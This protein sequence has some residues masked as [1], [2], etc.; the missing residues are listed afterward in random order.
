MPPVVAQTRLHLFDRDRVAYVVAA[1]A[2]D[3]L[4]EL[5]AHQAVLHQLLNGLFR[6]A[7]LLVD[8]CCKRLYFVERELTAHFLEQCF[9][10]CK[11]KI[12][13]IYLPKKILGCTEKHSAGCPSAPSAAQLPTPYFGACLLLLYC[14][15]GICQGFNRLLP[16]NFSTL[17]VRSGRLF[18][19]LNYAACN[20]RFPFQFVIAY[21][22]LRT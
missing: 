5:N 10:F 2:A 19:S 9:F 6:I 11:P 18:P 4:R 14:L 16:E 12:H 7:L 21:C 8:L 13:A 20:L 22:P 17:F 3:F 15:P 1:G